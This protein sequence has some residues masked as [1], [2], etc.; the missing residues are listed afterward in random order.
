DGGTAK[1]LPVPP[2]CPDPPC[3]GAW[4]RGRH[5]SADGVRACLVPGVIGIS[6]GWQAATGLLAGLGAGCPA[7]AARVAPCL[8]FQLRSG[9]VGLPAPRGL[10]PPGGAPCPGQSTPSGLCPSP[11]SLPPYSPP[12]SPS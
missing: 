7:T 8:A 2:S 9:G 6:L 3:T 12:P 5:R 11:S 10:A 4:R 1:P